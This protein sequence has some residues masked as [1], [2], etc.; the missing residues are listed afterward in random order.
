MCQSQLSS[1]MLPSEAPIPPCAAT[2]WERV[3]K[4]LVRT[5][6]LSPACA[7]SSAARIPEPPAPTITASN[8][9]TGIAM[10]A[11]PEDRDDPDEIEQERDHDRHLQ[12]EAHS[13]RMDVIHED[14]AH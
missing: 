5:A 3:G 1:P 2:V 6:T 10:S 8:L 12:R 13:R 7:S 14:V 4:T 11:A 9:R